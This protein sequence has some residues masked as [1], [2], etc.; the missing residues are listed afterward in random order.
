[1]IRVFLIESLLLGAA[2]ITLGL[3]VGKA[4]SVL[5]SANVPQWPTAGRNLALV[6]MLFDL[7]VIAFAVLLGLVVSVAGGLWPAWLALR[8][9]MAIHQRTAG[10]VNVFFVVERRIFVRADGNVEFAAR[11]DAPESIETGLVKKNHPS[12]ALHYFCSR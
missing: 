12:G 6:P 4:L 8:R 3:A 11:I 10:G 1:M 2:G 7:R 9:P 5:I